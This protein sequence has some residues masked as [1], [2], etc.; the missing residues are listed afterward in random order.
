MNKGTKIRTVLLIV[1]LLN[2]ANVQLG[3]WEF[4]NAVLNN[5]YAAFSYLLALGA[6]IAAW[7]FNNDF[8]PEACIG[9][10]ITRQLKLEKQDGYV[11]D[12]LFS[13]LE[14]IADPDD[15]NALEDMD[16]E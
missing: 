8:T 6:V 16:N 10:G 9:T 1:A 5:I 13:A 12:S 4:H 11:G 14:E 3:V 15:E 7:Y 2:Q